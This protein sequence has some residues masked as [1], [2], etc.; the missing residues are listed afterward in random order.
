M[1]ATEVTINESATLNNGQLGNLIQSTTSPC[2]NPGALNKR[3]AK[4]PQIPPVS[5]PKPSAQSGWE[6][7]G[8][9]QI[10]ATNAPIASNVKNIVRPVNE[11]N[12]APG[13]RA[14]S[15]RK[16]FPRIEREFFPSRE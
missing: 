7:F 5:E 12:A 1:K 9:Y 13:F 15:T 3:S 14:N 8:T 10:I 2:I 6:I 16:K 4:F 11:L